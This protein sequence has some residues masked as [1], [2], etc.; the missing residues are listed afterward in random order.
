MTTAAIALSLTA[1]AQAENNTSMYAGGYW[2]VVHVA[3][4]SDGVPM[5]M[6]QSQITFNHSSSN[7]VGFVQIKWI[8]SYSYPA[9]HLSRPNWHFP[10]DMQ[11][12]LSITLDSTPYEFVGVSRNANFKQSIVQ[13]VMTKDDGGDWLGNFASAE[14][15]TIAFRSGNEPQWS[16]K[17][18]GSR[19][20]Y[21]SF[22]S[23]IKL[24]EKKASPQ[25]TTS[26]VPENTQPVPTSP[27]PTVPIKKPK[28]DSI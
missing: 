25:E 4:N 12:P 14:T 1:A 2:K 26:P 11:L 8:N 27:V 7:S 9:I 19:K 10:P 5:C 6:M 20:A 15:M 28:G 13:I 18:T 21:E 23:C 16:V 3:R 24:L 17:M 22:Q